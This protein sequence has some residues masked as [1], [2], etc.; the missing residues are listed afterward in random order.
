[1]QNKIVM[2]KCSSTQN[3]TISN[4]TE[5]ILSKTAGYILLHFNMANGFRYHTGTCFKNT[6][7]R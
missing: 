4:E 2:E 1:M 7:V 3:N 5:W 6:T